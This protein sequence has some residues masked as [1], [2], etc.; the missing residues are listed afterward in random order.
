MRKEDKWAD[1]LKEELDDYL[2][3]VPENLWNKLEA[4][5]QP[6]SRVIPFW[7][8]WQTA[9]AVA[10][11]IV[12]LFSFWTVWLMQDVDTPELPVT[13]DNHIQT[14]TDY[15]V[16]TPQ[17]EPHAVLQRPRLMA[18]A[19]MVKADS[20]QEDV[21][22]VTVAFVSEQFSEP[23]DHNEERVDTSVSADVDESVR[24]DEAEVRSARTRSYSARNYK[25]TA[26]RT[27]RSEK[28]GLQLGVSYGNS[29]VSY[30]N[31]Y[32]GFATLSR[33]SVP[34]IADINNHPSADGAPSVYSQIMYNARN[35]EVE[36][37]IDHAMPV[38]VG[39]TVQYRFNDDWSL[40]SGLVYTL[41]SSKLHSGT[42]KTYIQSRQKLHYIG[43]PLKVHRRIWDN[44]YWEVYASAGGMMEKCVSASRTNIG[45][46]V[47]AESRETEDLDVRR[48]QFSLAA[49]AGVQFK[50]N[51]W[52]GIYA[53]PGLTYYFD[54]GEETMTI[55]KEHPFNFSL[56]V[57]L[58][59]TLP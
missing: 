34:P 44:R 28:H 50:F 40:E 31:T 43:I 27:A 51:N 33:A 5:L 11:A 25:G 41:L 7:R 18:D 32:S 21:R 39:A 58:R 45:V 29:L 57:G 47:Q 22:P 49:A 52:S 48:L 6:A 42:G 35:E 54:D 26:N 17:A 46:S 13:A 9:V 55:R 20:Q 23:A 4:E 15:S 38:T 14:V 53:E 19:R 36:S 59:F 56:Q 24:Q 10:A 2:E 3:P 16:Q 37:E 30:N 8:K 1:R 12:M